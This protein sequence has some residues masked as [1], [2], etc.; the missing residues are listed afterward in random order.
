M[1]GTTWAPA[2][3][4]GLGVLGLLVG[5]A[6]ARLHRRGWYRR[7]QDPRPGRV[8]RFCLA[9]AVPCCWL[10]LTPALPAPTTAVDLAVVATHLALA[11]AVILASAVDI[12]VH[13]LPDLVTLPTTAAATLA[14]LTGL[15][16]GV[17]GHAVT[18]LLAGI[19]T[20]VILLACTIACG[21]IGLGDIKLSSALATLLGWHGLYTVVSGVIYT[22]V[23]AGAFALALLARGRANRRTP[24]PLGPF[25]G[26]GG[27]L[28]LIG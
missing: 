10:L 9:A 1:Q 20:P 4:V 6:T 13:R 16:L 24:L 7:P 22:C 28:A 18:A 2:T 12:E 25:L 19:L 27:L 17:P 15:L 5:S 11:W 3:L 14:A 23:L 8:R 21:G 26:L